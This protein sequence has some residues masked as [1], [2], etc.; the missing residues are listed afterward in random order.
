MARKA[1]AGENLDE[2]LYDT[3]VDYYN[4]NNVRAQLVT[5]EGGSPKRTWGTIRKAVAYR[6]SGE[7]LVIF[8]IDGEPDSQAS[9]ISTENLQDEHGRPLPTHVSVTAERNVPPMSTDTAALAGPMYPAAGVD[10]IDQIFATFAPQHPVS[11]E[12]QAFYKQSVSTDPSYLTQYMAAY[13]MSTQAW[14]LVQTAT[15]YKALLDAYQIATPVHVLE[16]MVEQPVAP[17][18]PPP[19]VA[20]PQAPMAPPQLPGLPAPQVPV[21]APA[22]PQPLPTL[23]AQGVATLPVA[24]VPQPL[25]LPLPG[26]VPQV[27][28]PPAPAATGQTLTPAAAPEE[29]KTRGK[30]KKGEAADNGGDD[31]LGAAAALYPHYVQDPVNFQTNLTNLLGILKAL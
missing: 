3:F 10:P 29:K 4:L 25:P 23:P 17:P 18:P 20:Q 27:P 31:L 2:L 22:A 11:A 12:F 6:D 30:G 26:A 21:A 9:S 19:P 16:A 24:G 8:C 14:T 5:E 13:N 28:T 1:K 15:L 7:L